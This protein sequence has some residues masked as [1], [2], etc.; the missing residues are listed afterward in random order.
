MIHSTVLTT[1]IVIG[2]SPKPPPML[3]SASILIKMISCHT[4]IYTVSKCHTRGESEN[5]T[6]E[7]AKVIYPGFKNQAEFTRSTKQCMSGSPKKIYK[8]TFHT[9]NT[10][11]FIFK[12]C[13]MRLL[14]CF[15]VPLVMLAK[16]VRR[17]ITA[18]FLQ[19]HY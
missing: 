17:V 4:D 18:Y 13:Y 3:V 19:M 6:S 12:S 7:K 14:L 1:R 5:H 15:S 11:T 16:F 2:S 8:K 9:R 10:L